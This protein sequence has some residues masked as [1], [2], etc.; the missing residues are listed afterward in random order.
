MKL[1]LRLYPAAWRERYGEEFAALLDER[2]LSPFDVLDIAF[3]AFDARLRPRALA[4]DLAPRRKRFMHG[5][6][7][8]IGALVGGGLLLAMIG[9]GFLVPD[10][11]AAAAYLYPVAAIALLAALFGLSAHQG[12]RNPAL[13]WAAVALPVAGLAVGLIGIIG[14]AVV[15]DRPFIGDQNA[16]SVWMFGNVGAVAGSVLFAAATLAVRV[17]SRAAA[18]TLLAGSVLLLTIAV[19]VLA[20]VIG[21]EEAAYL[22]PLAVV[23]GVAFC[24][25]WIWLGAASMG[26]FP[27][28]RE[29]E[30]T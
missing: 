8:G 6:I 21:D 9:I 18:G 25:G 7:G 3:G 11:G 26:L 2:P 14:S 19:P 22:A 24:L 5:R 20:G 12:R 16:W 13:V 4:L 23:G 15:G 28:G 17:F 29:V 27:G 10:S 30:T 1:L